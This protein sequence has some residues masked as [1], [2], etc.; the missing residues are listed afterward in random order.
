MKVIL[1]DVRIAFAKI[2]EPEQFNGTGE[3]ACSASFIID[4]TRQAS[5]LKKIA[6]TIKAVAVEKWKEKATTT[7]QSLKAKGDLC[8]HSGAEKADYDGFADMMFIA[9]R[10]KARPIVVDRQKN[11]LT[12]AD[13]K[14]YSG[15]YVN[16]AVDIWAQDN[17]YGKRVNAKLLSIQFVRDGDAFGGGAPGS[18]DDFDEIAGEDEGVE[19]SGNADDLF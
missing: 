4:P 3:P 2:W 11:P 18:A 9:A 16:V 8:L 15:C 13:G 17:G 1:S 5:E 12:A 19:T 10:N 14:P 6:D 7:L